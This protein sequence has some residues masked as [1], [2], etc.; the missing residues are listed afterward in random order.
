MPEAVLKC[1]ECGAVVAEGAVDCLTRWHTLLAL[2]HSHRAPWG[3]LHGLEFATYMLQHPRSTPPDVLDRCWGVLYRLVEL[4]HTPEQ[5]FQDMR[6]LPKRAAVPGAPPRPAAAPSH[7]SMTIQDLGSFEEE[8]Y[9]TLLYEWA[10]ATITEWK[11][12]AQN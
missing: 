12:G 7:F 8:S 3:P 1:P 11:T 9:E 10:R 5:V 2:D 4:Q 6:L